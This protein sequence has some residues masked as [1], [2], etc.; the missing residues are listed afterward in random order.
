MNNSDRSLWIGFDIKGEA[1][2]CMHPQKIEFWKDEDFKRI[3]PEAPFHYRSD[4]LIGL[5]SIHLNQH[6]KNPFSAPKMNF[7]F[8]FEAWQALEPHHQLFLRSQQRVNAL[9]NHLKDTPTL[10]TS[11]FE[12]SFTDVLDSC[13]HSWGVD[14]EGLTQLIGSIDFLETKMEKPL[15][16]NFNL[17][18]SRAMVDKFH[19]L[20][21]LLFNLRSL[22]ALDYNSYIQDP[23]HEAIKVDSITD[24]L[25]KAEYVANDAL[26]YFNFRRLRE[27]MPEN[28]AEE[29]TKS[30]RQLSHNGYCLIEN[31]PKSFLNSLNQQDLEE[32]LYIAQMDWLLGTDAGLLFRI[33]EE[34]FGLEEGYNQIFW[35]DI[36]TTQQPPH[37]KLSVA[38]ELTERDVFPTSEAA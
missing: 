9:R 31:L 5:S 10:I 12:R 24:Y 8:C 20:H 4:A 15:L 32:S 23:T 18:M 29:M 35:P 37:S 22:I 2:A 38:C 28:T 11:S 26:L 14:L 13:L 16:Y 21:S 25:A 1:G 27:R 30:F 19:Y 7:S 34:L 6:L 33:R 36:T 3:T 17:K